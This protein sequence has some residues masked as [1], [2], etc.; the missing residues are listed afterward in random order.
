M[1]LAVLLPVKPPASVT[2]AVIVW[3]PEVRVLE[4]LPPLPREPSILDFQVRLEVRFPFC[5]SVAVPLKLTVAP[6]AKVAPFPG[7][8]RVTTGAV[9]G[10]G[11]GAGVPAAVNVST[12]LL[13][14][15]PVPVFTLK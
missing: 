15:V 12:G 10:A 6:E 11:A 1:I 2:E 7:L 14:E 13:F 8:T 5:V 3:V 9:F 4:K